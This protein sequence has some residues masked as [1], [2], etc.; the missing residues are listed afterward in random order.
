DPVGQAHPNA[1]LHR[2]AAA[3]RHAVDRAIG[4]VVPRFEQRLRSLHHSLLPC[5]H[6]LEHLLERALERDRGIARRGGRRLR[7]GRLVLAGPLGE[8]RGQHEGSRRAHADGSGA[9]SEGRSALARH[10]TFLP[11]RLD[12][13][14]GPS[15]A[16]HGRGLERR[17]SGGGRCRVRANARAIGV[18]VARRLLQRLF[19]SGSRERLEMAQA[20]ADHGRYAE[21]PRDFSRPAWGDVLRRVKSSTSEDNLSLVA[22]GAAFYAL[23]AIFPALAALVAIYGLFT[24]PAT[25]TQQLDRV[26]DIIP[27]EA[28]MIL[29][30]Q[31]Q[32]VASAGS[33]A[34][35]IGAAASFL[36]ALWSA[37]K[38]VK[39][40]MTALN[41][42]Y[43]ERE[44]RGFIKFNG[45]AL[46]LTL[47]VLA[48]VLV[49][50]VAV[51]VVPAIAG[52]LNLPP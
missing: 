15:V 26:A 24:D 49:A 27:D 34:L 37:S 12:G 43:G 22:A 10:G 47:V 52:L 38:G 42:V 33:T 50:L 5:A 14:I 25:V 8:R 36:F 19:G 21:R 9:R 4:Q 30:S 51:A 13:V 40:L 45:T 48:F 16:A 35:S 31:L 17:S 29:E 28:R 41:I 46:L 23:L 39:S 11:Q 3:H 6:L 44:E 2:F 1:A 18:T 20:H 7:A 32:R